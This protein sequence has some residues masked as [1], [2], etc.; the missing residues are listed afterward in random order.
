MCSIR[1][2]LTYGLEK[3]FISAETPFRR[4]AQKCMTTGKFNAKAFFASIDAQRLARGLSWRKVAEQAQ[5]SASTL[6]RM[7]QGHRLD[8]DTLAAL[9]AWSGLKADDFMR[10]ERQRQ[11]RAES[12][13]QMTAHLHGDPNLSKE[14][15]KA[16]EAALK[17]AY[18]EFRKR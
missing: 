1:A 14:G 12:L 9:C 16:L 10:V 6:T 7:S 15:A 13:A 11:S 4:E 18:Q 2:I 3:S 17:A 8:V 5:V